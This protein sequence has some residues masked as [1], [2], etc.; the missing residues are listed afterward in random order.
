[1][2][3]LDNKGFAIASILYSIMVLFLLLL[4]SILGILGNRKAILDKNK[5]DILEK[6]N[7]DFLYNK[8]NFEHKNITIINR[9]NLDDIRF[10]L[11][12]GVTAIDENGNDIDIKKIKYNL[13]LNNIENKSYNVTYT[14]SMDDQIITS[15]RQ[16]TF[17]SDSSDY[18]D[19]YDYIGNLQTFTSNYNGSYSIELWGAQGGSINGEG[20]TSDNVSRGSLSYN[21]GHGAY[22]YGLINL[23]KNLSLYIYVGGKGCD[24]VQGTGGCETGGYNGGGNLLSGQDIYGASGGGATDIRL[25]G[26]LWNDFAGL[27][28]RIMVASGGGGANFRN[29]GFG[30]GNG[31]EG[32]TL[33][34][35]NGYESLSEDS[36]FQNELNIGYSIGIGG[37]QTTGG[38][39]TIYN[40]DGTTDDAKIDEANTLSNLGYFGYANLN[41][42][43][44]GGGSGYYAGGSSNYGGAAG[45]SSFISGYVGCDAITENSTVDN[46]KHTGQSVHYSGY[47]FKNAVMYAGNEEVPIHNGNSTMIGNSG[48]GYAKISLIYYY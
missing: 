4:L 5:K 31:G 45:G 18:V 35:I 16:I 32:G 6:I 25:V 21:G 30:E 26:G 24:N 23:K 2:K 27:K 36:Y 46:I 40:T 34:G 20:L 28:S 15:T 44:S 12:D 13:D 1:M 33:N 19:N 9:G 11:L 3:K 43:Q 37:T 14:V 22:T 38:Y 48:N 8:I 42:N 41:G 7:K 29:N 10:A 17:V 47:K 39:A